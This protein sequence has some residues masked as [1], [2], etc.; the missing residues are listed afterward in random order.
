MNFGAAVISSNSQGAG[1]ASIRGI[2][3]TTGS[4]YAWTVQAFAQ[5]PNAY[6]YASDATGIIA[7]STQAISVGQ[8]PNEVKLEFTARSDLVNVGVKF[9]GASL[10]DNVYI[11]EVDL[12]ESSCVG[13]T[14]SFARG[15]LK[16]TWTGLADDS[17]RI[18]YQKIRKGPLS[19]VRMSSLKNMLTVAPSVNNVSLG[20]S[21][22]GSLTDIG[23]ACNAGN[24]ASNS[25]LRGLGSADSGGFS[26][27]FDFAIVSGNRTLNNLSLL[28]CTTACSQD[29]QCKALTWT[30]S[31]N[32][33]SLAYTTTAVATPNSIAA[34]RRALGTRYFRIRQNS[35]MSQP[36]QVAKAVLFTGFGLNNMAPAI[37]VTAT[38]TTVGSK[39]SHVIIGDPKLSW[40]AA[41]SSEQ[42]LTFDYGTQRTSVRSVFVQSQSSWPNTLVFEESDDGIV[43]WYI[44]SVDGV[45]QNA[46]IDVI[47]INGG[48]GGSVNPVYTFKRGSGFMFQDICSMINCGSDSTYSLV[49][50]FNIDAPGG[51]GSRTKTL[52]ST[53]DSTSAL[54]TKDSFISMTGSTSRGG[55]LVNGYSWTRMGISVAKDSIAVNTMGNQDLF[56]TD[57]TAFRISGTSQN[58]RLFTNGLSDGKCSISAD[59]PV[60]LV[61][62]VMLF[63]RPLSVNEL[64]NVVESMRVKCGGAPGECSDHGY[65]RDGHC[66]CERSE[67]GGWKGETCS[68]V[69]CPGIPECNDRGSCSHGACQ[70]D[71]QYTGVSCES[72]KCPGG[73][74]PCSGHGTCTTSWDVTYCTCQP[75]YRGADCSLHIC[76]GDLALPNGQYVQCSGNG[77]CD[78]ATGTC[79]CA[80]GVSTNVRGY[81]I[82]QG[83]EGSLINFQCN[84]GL[85][86][87]MTARYGRSDTLSCASTSPSVGYSCHS[88]TSLFVVRNLCEGRTTCSVSASYTLFG[89]PCVGVNKELIVSY[90]CV[91]STNT[92]E[93]AGTDCSLRIPITSLAMDLDARA[94]QG[95]PIASTGS[96]NLQWAAKNTELRDGAKAWYLP[97][98]NMWVSSGEYAVTQAYTIAYWLDWRRWNND[99]RTLIRGDSDHQVIVMH[100]STSLGSWDNRG[101]SG[102]HN[103]ST[104]IKY[105]WEL[106]ITM[107]TGTNDSTYFGNQDFIECRSS[108]HFCRYS[109][110]TDRAFS[111]NKVKWLGYSTQGP[112][113]VAQVLI[114]ERYLSGAEM[115][116]LWD[117]TKSSFGMNYVY[118]GCFLDY[119]GTGRAMGS[120]ETD[121]AVSDLLTMP[122]GNREDPI[123]ACARAALRKGFQIFAVQVGFQFSQSDIVDL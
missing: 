18:L 101:F 38:T 105:G 70:C 88:E 58:L 63:S 30:S 112:G 97:D 96:S 4:T 40:V 81:K 51:T 89:D 79:A 123:D 17:G 119:A 82:I 74:V 16:G 116:Q 7:T 72:K 108:S 43:W 48:V 77:V 113:H 54:A 37:N 73:D 53:Q 39:A 23:L 102:F 68:T 26:F 109:G 64:E 9:T 92:L 50:S 33:C 20:G 107:G 83:C 55:T 99:F 84:D 44:S 86:H 5:Y 2:V 61:N 21:G 24:N 67:I 12:P 45:V 56:S 75:G 36:W 98:T 47:G 15:Q 103:S 8:S 106:L 29:S 118:V 1:G 52:L 85:I 3:V 32:V 94:Y 100:D 41:S 93:I 57:P 90:S 22:L 35:T 122:V 42:A 28:E 114:Y 62:E 65:C 80:F 69:A 11:T 66:V 78:T 14:G 46:T 104:N 49:M 25:D 121:T 10:G 60:G 6:L 71:S 19:H 111:G 13:K 117:A 120:L 59:N 27:Q 76:P 34:F 110:N 87:I 91:L 31:I 115:I 95:G